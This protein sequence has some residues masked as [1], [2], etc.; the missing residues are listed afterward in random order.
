MGCQASAPAGPPGQRPGW[1]APLPRAPVGRLRL[2]HPAR[3]DQKDLAWPGFFLGPASAQDPAGPDQEDPAWPG[4]LLRAAFCK[5]RLGRDSL[6]PGRVTSPQAGLTPSGPRFTPS[7]PFLSSG[8]D[9]SALCQP[10]DALWLR[11]AHPPSLYAGLGTPLGSDQHTPHLLVSLI[12]RR[13]IRLMTWRSRRQQLED[14]AKD[15]KD[16]QD[17]TCP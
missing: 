14:E 10:W 3:P 4:F 5:P 2:Q 8:I 6:G 15:S 13:R 16:S 12:L 11:L 7:G 17:G 9:F 1:A